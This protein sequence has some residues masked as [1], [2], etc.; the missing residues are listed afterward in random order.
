MRE[1]RAVMCP[2]ISPHDSNLLISGSETGKF[3]VY[4]MEKNC[5]KWD[6]NVPMIDTGSE[7]QAVN[8]SNNTNPNNTL[9]AHFFPAGVHEHLHFHQTVLDSHIENKYPLAQTF[10]MSISQVV[11]ER[12]QLNDCRYIAVGYGVTATLYAHF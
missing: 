12:S 5:N 8:I 6:A 7:I 3:I 10:T 11:D 9:Y 4:D 1:T 2:Q